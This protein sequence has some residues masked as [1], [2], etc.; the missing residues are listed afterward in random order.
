MATI[1]SSANISLGLAAVHQQNWKS[2]GHTLVIETKAYYGSE[3]KRIY[4]PTRTEISRSSF[5]FSFLLTDLIF[6]LF[7]KSLALP[8]RHSKSLS[9]VRFES[10]SKFESHAFS[11]SSLRNISIPRCVERF[12]IRCCFSC[13]WL[14]EVIFESEAFVRLSLRNIVIL[15]CVETLGESCFFSCESLHEVRFE[16]ESVLKTVESSIFSDYALTDI[17][18]PRSVQSVGSDAFADCQSLP[19]VTV[20]TPPHVTQVCETAF[21]GCSLILGSPRLPPNVRIMAEDL[22]HEADQCL[23]LIPLR[24]QNRVDIHGHFPFPSVV[25][26]SKSFED[27]TFIDHLATT[28]IDIKTHRRILTFP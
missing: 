18:I 26:H 13:E 12:G 5:G 20:G 17:I 21:N 8:I 24:F 4:M 16:S 19:S 3:L 1:S 9:Q 6:W 7:R 22:N 15:W 11:C 23:L 2:T 28:L 25:Y 10:K 14:G 27:C